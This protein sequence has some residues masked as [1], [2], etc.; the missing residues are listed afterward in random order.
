[1]KNVLIFRLGPA[2]TGPYGP[3]LAQMAPSAP[4]STLRG[5]V[6][7]SRPAR[8]RARRQVFGARAAPRTNGTV[9][10]G[11]HAA[12]SRARLPART[13]PCAQ[14]GVRRP[15]CAPNKRHFARRT[16]R[17]AVSARASAEDTL[18]STSRHLHAARA[19]T[20]LPGADT[21]G[22]QIAAARRSS[23]CAR[24]VLNKP[25]FVSHRTARSNRITAIR[26]ECKA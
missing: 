8:C 16:A 1:M 2:Q 10:P 26:Y 17:C 23:G 15:G 13:A 25:C 14:A 11:P 9:R 24:Y 18:S 21:V 5:P 7:G 20:A 19:R 4:D 6:H 22:R 12:R 3:R